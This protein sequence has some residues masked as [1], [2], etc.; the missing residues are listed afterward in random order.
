MF[1]VMDLSNSMKDD[2]ENLKRVSLELTE[3]MKQETEGSNFKIGFGSF[4]NR[5][6]W[7][8]I[9]PLL[10]FSTLISQI[11]GTDRHKLTKNL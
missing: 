1:F 8:F 4:V 11:C 10:G 9:N 2:L 7:P 6:M 3:R 5:P